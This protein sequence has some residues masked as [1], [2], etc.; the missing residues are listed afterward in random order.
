M[1][2][3]VW[4]I[5]FSIC[6]L[7]SLNGCSTPGA[8]KLGGFELPLTDIQQ[9]VLSELPLSNRSVSSNGREMVSNYFIFKNGKIEAPGISSVR[10]SLKVIVL[11]DR[12]P[13]SIQTLVSVEKRSG[14]GEYS[15]TGHDLRLA[16]IFALRI[17]TRLTKR[18]N[19]RNVIDDFRVF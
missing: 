18:P 5:L 8:H 2:F 14:R 4:S 17:Q 19:D 7:I 6:C 16:K 3:R 13:Y 10:Y 11:G 1:S 9:A 12:R 15:V